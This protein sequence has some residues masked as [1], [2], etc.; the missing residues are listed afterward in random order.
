MSHFVNEQK[1][2]DDNIS[3]VTESDQSNLDPQVY[4][5]RPH[6]PSFTRSQSPSSNTFNF[7]NSTGV[8]SNR[9][10]VPVSPSTSPPNQQSEYHNQLHVNFPSPPTY[11]QYHTL[12]LID[13]SN[14]NIGSDFNNNNNTSP[15]TPRYSTPTNGYF[16]LMPNTSKSQ[17]QSKSS[18]NDIN[19]TINDNNSRFNNST[20]MIGQPPKLNRRQSDHSD[21]SDKFHDYHY[22]NNRSITIPE[23]LNENH[24]Y[25]NDIQYDDYYNHNVNFI[26]GSNVDGNL[27]S[28]KS[29]H[30]QRRSD[31]ANWA[32]SRASPAEQS[33]NVAN[34][35]D[36]KVIEGDR[37]AMTSLPTSLVQ[38]KLFFKKTYF[39]FVLMILIG[40]F[41]LQYE[42]FIIIK[43][44]RRI[45]SRSTW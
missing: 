4:H 13:N 35:P 40:R 41:R 27:Y 23:S 3:D 6:S 2:Q 7:R 36:W 1:V 33:S 34:L 43:C 20:S 14:H 25:E 29:K 22:S 44:F 30:Q 11:K 21:R 26:H 28:N 9:K 24:D 15:S 39:N 45:N 12:P 38:V 18:Y 17:I 8:S 5:N 16:S 19:D 32:P 37:R 31:L 10:P 42:T